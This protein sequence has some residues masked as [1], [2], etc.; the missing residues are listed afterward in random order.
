MR[1]ISYASRTL[2]PSERN[3][4]YHSGKLELL[5]LKWAVCEE[6]RDILHYAPEFT[7]YTDDNP[8]TYIMTTAK[9]NAATH[10]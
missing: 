2:N 6:F 10:R 3:Y 4:H 8:L 9:L 5:A 7:V 1:V